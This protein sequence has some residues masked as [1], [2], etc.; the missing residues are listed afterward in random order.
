MIAYHASQ[1]LLGNIPGLVFIALAVLHN[2][3][4]NS[5]HKLSPGM[6]ASIGGLIVQI[7]FSSLFMLYWNMGLLGAGL[8]VSVS[9]IFQ[10]VFFFCMLY[11][12]PEIRPA[13]IMPRFNREQWV[14]IKE[15]CAIGIPSML[16][17]CLEIAGVELMQPLAGRISATSSGA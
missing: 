2:Y 13:L 5:F 6:F 14:Y 4:L 17:A 15:F 12:Y 16:M 11:C 1:F 3:F 10:S 8:A 9:N 7:I